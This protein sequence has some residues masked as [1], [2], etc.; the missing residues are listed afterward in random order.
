MVS[1]SSSFDSSNRLTSGFVSSGD[2]R[3]A[4]DD[5]FVTRSDN[6]RTTLRATVLLS[7]V[8]F[9]SS[10]SGRTATMDSS[11]ALTTSE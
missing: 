5:S 8:V 7:V 9:S 4:N 3:E 10:L 11:S 2:S 1:R 6:S